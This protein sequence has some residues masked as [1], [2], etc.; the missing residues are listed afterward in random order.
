[1]NAAEGVCLRYA[2]QND[3][4]PMLTVL[5]DNG[6]DV[7]CHNGAWPMGRVASQRR[8]LE[9]LKLMLSAPGSGKADPRYSRALLYVLGENFV[10]PHTRDGRL[11]TEDH[12]C[13]AAKLLV[14]AGAQS[15]FPSR[16]PLEKQLKSYI[17]ERVV[18]S[19]FFD[20]D[21][22]RPRCCEALRLPC[23]NVP[24]RKEMTTL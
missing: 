20:V 4:V 22:C 13:R 10:V 17:A 1:M 24:L 11:E 19:H 16:L 7:F 2:V 18:A 6:A 3:D 15:P 14:A 5:L 9:Q 23:L 8:A 12:M 21:S